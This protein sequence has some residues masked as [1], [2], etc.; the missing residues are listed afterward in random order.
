MCAENIYYYLKL[1]QLFTSINRISRRQQLAFLLSYSLLFFALC[2]LFITLLPSN[3][4]THH[5]FLCPIPFSV[6]SRSVRL[7]AL[8]SLLLLLLL[9]FL[10]LLCLSPFIFGS[11]WAL[12]CARC[13]LAT[14]S[15]LHSFASSACNLR[16]LSTRR[17]APPPPAPALCEPLAFW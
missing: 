5:A 10:L 9:L 14:V 8:P 4:M 2:S 17:L 16:R 3:H 7:F 1:D 12:L 11:C 13:C 6:C 15:H